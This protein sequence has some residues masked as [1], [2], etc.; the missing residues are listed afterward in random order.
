[1]EKFL[2]CCFHQN[3]GPEQDETVVMITLRE[4]YER[5]KY[6]DDIGYDENDN[7]LPDVGETRNRLS[8]ICA[9]YDLENTM[10]CTYVV[11]ATPDEIKAAL[12]AEPDFAFS[13]EFLQNWLEDIIEEDPKAYTFPTG[14]SV[15]PESDE[16][17][18][19]SI[20][21]SGI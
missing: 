7:E 14:S 21:D 16:P 8:A 5:E 3:F 11:D 18:E 17:G 20:W 19:P 9:K 15:T 1:M 12:E 10:E 2:F 13:E 4:P 6:P